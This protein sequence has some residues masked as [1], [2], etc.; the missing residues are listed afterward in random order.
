[1]ADRVYAGSPLRKVGP[2]VQLATAYRLAGELGAA[3]SLYREILGSLR[4]VGRERTADA[5]NIYSNWAAVKSDAGDI[6]GA[7]QLI[8]SAIE[9]GRALRPGEE[10]DQVVSVNYA[11]RLIILNRPAQAEPFLSKAREVAAGEGDLDMQAIPLLAMVSA[12]RTSGDLRAAEAALSSARTFIAA[13]FPEDHPA[14]RSLLLETGMLRLAGGSLTAA[15]AALLQASTAY[16]HSTSRITNEVQVFAGLAQ[17]EIGLGDFQAAAAHSTQAYNLS[18]KFVIAGSPSYWV[19]YCL[20]VQAKV[21]AA[22]H[23][24]AAMHDL[25]VRAASQLGPTVGK[26]HPLTREAVSLAGG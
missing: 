13:H 2:R 5:V 8:G 16:S 24:A 17:V 23:R 19:G 21:Q 14:R 22:A 4:S 25:A 15:K 9:I 18:S 7:L 10:P 26:D 20:L 6:L 12:A 11:K 3:D 1:L